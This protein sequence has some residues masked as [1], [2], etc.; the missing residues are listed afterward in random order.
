M[1][2][3]LAAGA[4]L[5]MGMCASLARPGCSGGSLKG[6][7]STSCKDVVERE[8]VL[9]RRPLRWRGKASLPGPWTAAACTRLLSAAAERPSFNLAALALLRPNGHGISWM[10]AGR[11]GDGD[12]DGGGC[13]RSSAVSPAQK[14]DCA[15]RELGGVVRGEARRVH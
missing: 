11:P 8:L 12:G 6:F 13:V 10:H 2:S 1:S 7:F 9:L 4:G 14:R 3:A 15:R 5:G